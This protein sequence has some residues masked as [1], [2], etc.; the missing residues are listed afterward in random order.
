M[1]TKTENT[2]LDYLGICKRAV[3]TLARRGVCEFIERDELVSI[4]CL[5]LVTAGV[6]EK[7]L[8]VTVA[9]RAMIDAIRGNEVRQRGRRD[10]SS[11]DNES[12]AGD[13]WD[14]LVYSSVNIAPA[15]SLDVWEA[16]K[17]LPALQ[18][19]VIMLY[20]WGGESQCSIAET[21][22]VDQT[23]VSRLIIAAKKNLRGC[24]NSGVQSITTVEGKNA[25]ETGRRSH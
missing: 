19:R 12:P 22:G 4:G 5:A 2:E 23:T 11:R 16:M 17:A 9:R 24:I 10:V 25:A 13:A 8:G 21:L 6:T 3:G 14:A 15:R 20:F 7:A 1:N 18:F